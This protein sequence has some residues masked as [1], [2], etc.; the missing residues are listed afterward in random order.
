ME[1]SPPLVLAFLVWVPVGIWI[2][3]VISWMVMADMDTG[4]GIIALGA[5][6]GLGI[7]TSF[8]PDRSIAWIPFTVAVLTV[9]LFP[10]VNESYRKYMLFK[11]DIEQI[12]DI[13]SRLRVNRDDVYGMIRLSEVLYGMGMQHQAITLLESALRERPKDLFPSETRTLDGWQRNL[14]KIPLRRETACLA[15]GTGNSPA[16]FFCRKC[17]AEFLLEMARRRWVGFSSWAL[18]FS[19]W[20]LLAIAVAAAPF[21]GSSQVTPE[22]RLVAGIVALVVALGGFGMLAWRGVRG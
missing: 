6:I 5:A 22:I 21:L 11:I 1:I 2:Y 19:V 8:A 17:G 4:T 3:A 10:L 7:S 9:A 12:E 16:Q 14:G 13:Y 15:C 18:L 20:G